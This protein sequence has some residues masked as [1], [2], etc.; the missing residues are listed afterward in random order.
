[1]NK[2]ASEVDLGPESCIHRIFLLFYVTKY[3]QGK[4]VKEKWL[5]VIGVSEDCNKFVKILG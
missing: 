5:Y 3:Y 4:A 2:I 1:V